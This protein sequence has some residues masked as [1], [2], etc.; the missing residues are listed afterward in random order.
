M[1]VTSLVALNLGACSLPS[2]GLLSDDEGGARIIDAT[3][4]PGSD[5]GAASD[6]AMGGEGA[7]PFDGASMA[8][9]RDAQ[10]ADGS[11][12]D[13]NDSSNTADAGGG[14]MGADGGFPCSG[15]IA[16]A[17]ID[18]R[19]GG[20]DFCVN[21]RACAACVDVQDDSNC[22][23]AYGASGGSFLCISGVCSAGDCRTSADCSG[24]A[25]GPLCGASTP[26]RCGLCT[27]D[28]RCASAFPAAPVCNLTTGLCASDLCTSTGSNPPP[29]CPVSPA[30]VCCAGRCRAG[31]PRA[32]CPGPGADA[33]CAATLA[34]AQGLCIGGTCSVCPPAS[35]G[36]YAVD[37]IN[38][39]D[40]AGT[41]AR[42]TPRCAFQTITAA[43]S[44]IGR[45]SA[46]ISPNTVIVV[47][48]STVQ[49]GES[50][51]LTVPAHVSVVTSSG[52]VT[53]NVAPGVSGFVL[54]APGAAVAGGPGAP[55]TLAGTGAAT[56]G[57]A[58]AR[59]SDLTTRLQQVT[60][61]GFAGAGIWIHGSG[62]LW[63]GPGVVSTRNG[64]ATAPASGLH[65][66][67]SAQAQIDV[68]AGSAPT[69]FDANTNHGILVEGSAFVTVS[70]A[71]TDALAG[72]GTITTN[73]NS[74]AGLWIAQTP[75]SPANVVSGLVS[76]GS[77]AGNGMRFFAGSTVTLRDSVSLG[78]SSAGVRVSDTTASVDLTGI[79][80]G[81][82]VATEYGHNVFQASGPA[83]N[84]GAGVCLDLSNGATDVLVAAGNLFRSARCDTPGAV[85]T[86]QTGGCRGTCGGLPCDLGIIDPVGSSDIDV[87]A[88]THP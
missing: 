68:A 67:E 66:T 62:A 16:T 26:R 22:T 10:D 88:C 52:P 77:V 50:F 83:H 37:P 53:I 76:F 85:L 64:S 19:T 24:S 13:A 46:P 86:L 54:A 78:N 35:G 80:L 56:N 7:V 25:S 63:I 87:T 69:H 48:P 57:I 70:G 36:V 30:D 38:G 84:S 27:T 75:G 17:C 31:G 3:T 41:G 74:Q 82:P 1:V 49:A 18:P 71:V 58:A 33:Y 20:N 29:V 55:L 32:C 39:S 47:G 8:P 21:G 79:D 65:V 11:G 15:P 43:L 51:P 28:A 72:V 14:V 40:R 6:I 61:T 44:F 59:G 2:G 12:S 81:R 60:I 73:F 9:D 45:S 4:V 42:T 34:P 5:A 23:A